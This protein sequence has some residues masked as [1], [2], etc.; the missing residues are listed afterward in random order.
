MVCV[1]E[2]KLLACHFG[3][4]QSCDDLEG[5]L[6]PVGQASLPV[7]TAWKAMFLPGLHVNGVRPSGRVAQ[8]GTLPK[9]EVRSSKSET[10]LKLDYRM[11]ERATLL[12]HSYFLRDA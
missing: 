7:M 11:N 5:H 2:D 1:A 12:Q 10:N 9:S 8:K 3:G 4:Q 6:P